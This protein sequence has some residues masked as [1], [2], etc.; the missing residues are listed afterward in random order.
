MI[1]LKIEEYINITIN[2][3]KVKDSLAAAQESQ[4]VLEKSIERN[5]K[6]IQALTNERA[7]L[8]KKLAEKTNN[9]EAIKAITEQLNKLK[10]ESIELQRDLQA[11]RDANAELS[12]KYNELDMKSQRDKEENNKNVEQLDKAIKDKESEL[13]RAGYELNEVYEVIEGK[14]KEIKDLELKIAEYEKEK[15]GA[16]S[17]TKELSEKISII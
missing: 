2:Y 10:N 1:R 13:I 8:T 17:D 14:E 9:Q 11:S 6:Q 7:E 5:Q 12:G 15:S 4:N 16:Q 3:N